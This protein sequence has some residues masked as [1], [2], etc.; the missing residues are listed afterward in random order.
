MNRATYAS[1]I[2]PAAVRTAADVKPANLLAQSV[3]NQFACYWMFTVELHE[4]N[5]S[6][7]TQVELRA[8]YA[9]VLP[10]SKEQ[11]RNVISMTAGVLRSGP[12]Q[13]L[14]R[15]WPINAAELPAAFMSDGT[16][17][18]KLLQLINIAQG[19]NEPITRALVRDLV[20]EEMR[21]R[22]ESSASAARAAD[23]A[24]V[25]ARTPESK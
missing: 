20:Q 9:C 1:L 5:S 22:A 18:D 7:E 16:C 11:L 4:G 14:A 10:A 19:M 2:Q 17:V 15:P 23:E 6:P 13:Y 24:D 8:R 21:T 25:V 12:G 3:N